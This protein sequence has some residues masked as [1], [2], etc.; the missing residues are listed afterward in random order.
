LKA[1]NSVNIQPEFRGEAKITWLVEEGKTVTKDEKLAEFDP[2]DTQNRIDELENQLIQYRTALESAQAQL[3]IE[4]RDSTASVEAAQFN[5]DLVRL[6]LERYLNGD[7]PNELRKFSLA[8]EKARSEFERATERFKQVPELAKEGFL[9]KINEEEERIKLREAEINKDSAEKELELYKKYTDPMERRQLEANVKDGDRVLKN[10]TEKAAI[11]TKERETRVSQSESQV[12]QAEQRLEKLKKELEHMTVLAPQPGIVHYGDPSRPWARD[13]VKVGNDFYRGNTL[14]TLP[15]L[16]EMQVLINVHEADIDLVKLEQVAHVTV[17]AVKGRV[18]NGKVTRIAP[19]ANTDWSESAN[20]TFQTEITMDPLTDVEMRSGITAH[21][22]IQ[23]E[24]L[25]D[26]LYVPIHAIASENGEHYC[27]LPEAEGFE[28]RAVKLGKNNLHYVVV[29]DGLQE[30]D[31][32][33]LYDPRS[34]AA[35]ERDDD[36]TSKPDDKA[37]APSNPGAAPAAQ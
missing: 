35:S 25:K 29:T 16:R 14:F 32:V 21:V 17:E 8:A 34:T 23:V 22:E 5:L 2:T 1:K 10:A 12:K 18:L 11:S 24:H 13:E 26:V 31:H 3:E 4:R 15:D 20:K 6:K 28:R 9:T 30:G 37:P 36:N 7:A 27:F 33:L 19:V